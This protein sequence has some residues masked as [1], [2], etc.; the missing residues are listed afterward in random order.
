MNYGKQG[1]FFVVTCSSDDIHFTHRFPYSGNVGAEKLAETI[2]YNHVID[3]VML[4]ANPMNDIMQLKI[5]N[6]LGK[7][8]RKNSSKNNNVPKEVVESQLAFKDDVIANKD[9]ELKAAYI[10]IK[11]PKATLTFKD[12]E[13][14]SLNK[15]KDEIIIKNNTIEERDAMLKSISGELAKKERAIKSKESEIASLKST[16]DNPLDIL[17]TYIKNKDEEIASLKGKLEHSISVDSTDD[18]EEEDVEN[19]NPAV[20]EKKNVNVVLKDNLAIRHKNNSNKEKKML[21]GILKTP[22]K[23]KTVPKGENKTTTSSSGEGDKKALVH[24]T[25]VEVEMNQCVLH[26]AIRCMNGMSSK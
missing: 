24:V 13:I 8:S 1:A 2:A 26:R 22:S 15:L 20:V 25:S 14:T 7:P 11:K 12:A 21:K 16:L 10:E 3:Q 17:C 6:V 4:D 23:E 18:D 5:R 19:T 9:A